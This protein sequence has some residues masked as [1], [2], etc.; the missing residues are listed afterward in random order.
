ME[1][2]RQANA[3]KLQQVADTEHNKDH[4][5]NCFDRFSHWDEAVDKPSD[6]AEDCDM[7]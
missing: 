5:E 3:E 2:P 4:P 7:K 1:M 6:Q